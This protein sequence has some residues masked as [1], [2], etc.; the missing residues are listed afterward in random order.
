MIKTTLI[1]LCLCLTS[2]VYGLEL[3]HSDKASI[4]LK[5]SY[6]NL[7]FTS[8][9]DATNN[10]FFADL[11]RVRTE[12]DAKFKIVSAKVIWDN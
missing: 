8:K 9:R 4:H 5:G 10:W 6:K 3:Y 7:A 1:L 2:P 11:N 12:W